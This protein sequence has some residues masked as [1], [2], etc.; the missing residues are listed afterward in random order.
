[1]VRGR[2]LIEALL[3]ML[4]RMELEK[5]ICRPPMLLVSERT[6]GFGTVVWPNTVLA[7]VAEPERSLEKT[8]VATTVLPKRAL[9]RTRRH[10]GM[11]GCRRGEV[12]SG[13][14]L[15]VMKCPGSGLNLE[16]NH[17]FGCHPPA[18]KIARTLQPMVSPLH[19]VI[20]AH[21][22]VAHGYGFLQR[23]KFK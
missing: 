18:I 3:K 17:T 21:H 14:V 16:V 13:R 8:A 19:A 4:R 20:I 2:R 7:T 12:V 5:K 6:V 23:R 22:S 9:S 15:E 1:M 11:S 10:H